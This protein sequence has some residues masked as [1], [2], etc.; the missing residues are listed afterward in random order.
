[1]GRGKRFKTAR[2]NKGMSQ[3]QFASELDCNPLTISLWERGLSFP[4]PS[5]VKRVADTLGVSIVFL[6]E[7]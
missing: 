5:R 1:M 4:R 2:L 3:R 7:G 6:R